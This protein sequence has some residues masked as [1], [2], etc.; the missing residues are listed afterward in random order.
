[1]EDHQLGTLA[2]SITASNHALSWFERCEERD[3]QA[4]ARGYPR[5]MAIA[6]AV[7]AVLQIESTTAEEKI[8]RLD[9]ET[10][11]I[12]FTLGTAPSLSTGS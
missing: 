4:A 2:A 1:M 3:M 7:I 8:L 12:T 5:S 6:L 10:T 11:E 9:P